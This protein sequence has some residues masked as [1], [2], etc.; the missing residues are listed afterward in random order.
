MQLCVVACELNTKSSDS[1]RLIVVGTGTSPE[2]EETRLVGIF[3]QI[4]RHQNKSFWGRQVS[5]NKQKYNLVLPPLPHHTFG[6]HGHTRKRGKR[7]GILAV[8]VTC[9][10]YV[11][12]TLLT[13]WL[14][15]CSPK[16]PG[17]YQVTMMMK[18][19]ATTTTISL[20]LLIVAFHQHQAWSFIL[21]SRKGHSR[22][23]C[24]ND[25]QLDL[26]LSSSTHNNPPVALSSP[27]RDEYSEA[28]QHFLEYLDK[29]EASLQKKVQRVQGRIHNYQ[30]SLQ[31][32]QTQRA[33]YT[34]TVTASSSQIR[35]QQST[36]SSP[37]L[38]LATA[39][40]RLWTQ[41]K[42]RLSSTSHRRR[43]PTPEYKFAYASN[44]TSI[45][46]FSGGS[47]I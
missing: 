12:F 47:G 40:R 37:L 30:Q 10:S 36:S 38:A 6:T 11:C 31:V 24:S 19:T 21:S 22:G 41:V 35:K 25:N 33:Q 1:H 8:C 45:S 34:A 5:T 4:Q 44:A 46:H 7:E 42:A 23:V 3:V 27:A 17:N 29:Q 28:M 2:V 14:A 39:G 13:R 9:G 18:T 32:I 15:G 43:P 16:R 20:L 26:S